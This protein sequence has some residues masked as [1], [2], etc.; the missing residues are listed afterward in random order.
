MMANYSIRIK[1]TFPEMKNL[2]IRKQIKLK[3]LKS[4]FSIPAHDNAPFESKK[5]FMAQLRGDV[6]T[7]TNITAQP[8]PIAVFIFLE[9]TKKEH[10]PK[11]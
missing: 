2:P 7:K 6:I 4:E 11:N 10:I 9:Q 8:N 3:K 5:R 1:V